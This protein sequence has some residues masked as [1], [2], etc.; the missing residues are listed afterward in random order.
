VVGPVEF[1]E[2]CALLQRLDELLIAGVERDFVARSLALHQKTLKR[3][4]TIN[5]QASFQ[6]ESRHALRCTIARE[7]LKESLREFCVHLA[8]SAQLQRFCLH[9]DLESVHIPGHSQLQRYANW[10]PEADMRAVITALTCQAQ[11]DDAPTTLGLAKS[12][13]LSTVWV[14]TTCAETN[15]HYPVDWILLR[16]AVRTLI[17]AIIVLREHGLMHRMPEPPTFLREINQLCIKMTHAGKGDKG[18]QKQK[19]ILREMKDLVKTVQGHAERYCRLVE[20]MS[21]PQGWAVAARRRMLAILGQLPKITHQA[22]ERIIGERQVANAE[23]VL[24]LYE[25]DSAVLSRGKSGAQ[26]EYGYSLLVAEQCEGLIM[27]WE[28]PQQPQADV[29]MVCAG[30]QRWQANYGKGTIRAAVTDRGC[31]GKATR[32]QLKEAGIAN[33]MCPRSPQEL[34]TRLKDQDFRDQLR[35]R[36]QTEGRIAIVKQTFLRGRLHT[37]QHEH[38]QVEIAW[39]I[40]AHNLWVLA[41]LPIANK[42]KLAA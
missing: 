4:M 26:V 14:D 9:G 5:E 2:F 17:Q 36:A 8:E 30:I 34:E 19:A 10:L 12:L 28:M 33:S 40:L 23:K 31:D 35:R 3:P 7:L 13:D 25:P 18:K 11:A 20:Q 22:H 41:R 38:Q 29:V 24:S 21:K 6:V 32:A 16:D 42:Q 27:D 15:I 39:V 37:K 1:V